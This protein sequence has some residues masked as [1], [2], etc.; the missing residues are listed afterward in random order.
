MIVIE[1]IIRFAIL[2]LLLCNI[3]G[4][5]LE[6]IGG[7]IGSITSY[8]TSILLIA[9]FILTKSKSKPLF[10]FILFGI[11]YFLISAINYDVLDTDNYFIKEFFRFML[12]VICGVE[13]LKKTSNENLYFVILIGGLSVVLN[14]LV[15][16]GI[17]SGRFSG[18]YLNP[19]YAG[20]ICLIGFA[21]SFS[22][23]N[24]KWKYIGQL[25]FTFGGLLTLS[26]TFI[27]IWVIINI[28][29]IYRNKKNFLAPV[30]GG[31]ALI[32]IFMFSSGIK[33]DKQ[34]FKAL[35][36]IFSNEKVNTQVIKHDT[37]DQTW[38]IYYDKIMD[39]PL[40][41]NGY[42]S[43][44]RRYSRYPGVH[45]SY[46]MVIGESGIIPFI[47]MFG[48]YS[49]LFVN[50]FRSFRKKP[51]LLYILVV[52]SLSLMA[53]HGYF[54]IFFNVF[55][56]MYIFIEI[57]KLKKEVKQNFIQSKVKKVEIHV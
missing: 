46:L 49:Y 4:F 25:V 29:A 28:I 8:L 2:I 1:K 48:I 7:S 34:R 47:I 56:S 13:V 10:P 38:A 5:L 24:I 43:F 53:S 52:I 30:I 33:F 32:L 27:I 18:F 14:G 40:I 37:R 6:Y 23:T 12:V 22:I 21:L 3:P 26:R 20:S 39:K 44:Q 11:S 15:F 31:L 50:S 9:Y 55:L 19:N 16:P 36:N 51:E 42:M 54:F 45:N 35:Q 17:A 57:Q 41:G